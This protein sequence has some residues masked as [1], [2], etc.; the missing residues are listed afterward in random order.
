[1]PG[2]KPLLFA[3]VALTTALTASL[4]FESVYHVSI[5]ARRPEPLAPLKNATDSR[6]APGRPAFTLRLVDSGGVG[7]P[8]AGEWGRDYSHDRKVFREVIL[9]EPPYIDAAAFQRVDLEWRSYVE[10]MLAYG[11]NAIAVP[12]LLELVDFDRLH[13]PDGSSGAAVYGAQS[14]F[15]ARHAAVRRHFEPLFEWTS[16]RG[17]QVYL[18]T[19]M[20]ALTPPLSRHLQT[21][22]PDASPLGIDTS[23]PAVWEVYRA[24]LEELFDELPSIQGLVIRFGEGGSLY[25]S[26]GWPYRSEMA[27]RN[28]ES[29]QVMLRGLLPVFEAR[30]KT[31]VLRSW[32]VGVGPLGRLHIDPRV[33]DTVLGDIDSPALVVSTKFTAGDF[34]S[35]LPLNPTLGGGRHRRVVEL[36]AKPEF[37]GFGAFPNF[38]GEE[39]ARALRVLS[40][41]NPRIVGTYVLSQFGGPLRAGPRTLYPLHG[42]WLWTDANVFVASRLAVDPS[43]DITEL[44]RTWARARFGNDER[45]VDAITRALTRTRDAVLEGFY[46][47]S[48]AERGVRIP[49]LE[50]PPLLW[51]FEWDMVGG[52]HSLLSIVY[53]SS[54]DDVDVAIEEGHAAAAVVRGVRQQVQTAFAAARP[55]TCGRICDETLRSLEYQE[56]LFDALAAWRQAFLSYYR[57]IDTGDSKAWTEWRAGREQFE[58]AATRHVTRFGHDPDFPAFD[59]T[60]ATQAVAAAERG[61]WARLFSAGL[62]VGLIALLAIGSPF[63]QRWGVPARLGALAGVGRLTWTTAVTPWRL[64]LE[65]VV[66]GSAVAVT[67]LALGLVAFLVGTLTGYATAWMAAASCLPFAS[68]A[69]AFES[70]GIGATERHGRGRFLVASV[71]PMI[72]GVIILFALITYLGPLGVWYWFWI[73]PVFRVVFLTVLVAMLLWTACIMFAAHTL[74]GWRGKLGGL[75]AAAGAGVVVLT[76]LLPEWGDAFRFL[77]RPLNLAPATDTMLFALRT[78][79]AVSLDIGGWSRVLGTLLLAGG[80]ALWLRSLV[81]AARAARS[82]PD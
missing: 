8:L 6:T 41:A 37:E 11:N 15:R 79:A 34:F 9:E 30:S 36:Q 64:G 24:G 12:L 7:I 82:A 62:L 20:L 65:P 31:L 10:R 78:Y 22:A 33:Y 49:G 29:L 1:M 25:N 23:D 61:A 27:V 26:D 3:G 13:L 38:L 57:W 18:D 81:R 46:I 44:A 67:M 45:I 47:R 55:G 72:P 32:T 71:G 51:I 58:I 60:S 35:Y 39:H 4:A 40:S 43:A 80:Y 74:D 2:P 69:L 28:A 52:W 53:R 77:D 50:L 14:P 48:F 76:A 56:T 54:R 42:F 63:G 16:Q 19:D 68:V 21:R 5:Q 17:M 73:L 75:L 70:T 59:L 66:F